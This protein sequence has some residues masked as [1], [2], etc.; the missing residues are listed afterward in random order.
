M[1]ELQLTMFS[2]PLAPVAQ[3]NDNADVYCDCLIESYFVSQVL[4]LQFV[5]WSLFG[6]VS[7]EFWPSNSTSR[8]A[9]SF[10]WLSDELMYH[11]VTHCEECNSIYSVS[12]SQQAAKCWITIAT[13]LNE[14]CWRL[15]AT[16][17]YDECTE[18]G[19][20]EICAK[21]LRNIL[22]LKYFVLFCFLINCWF[23][24]W[25]LLTINQNTTSR[26]RSYSASAP[27]TVY[28]LLFCV[29]IVLLYQ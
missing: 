28:M 19:W 1:V 7:V 23:L 5:F 16:S 10:G 4:L 8:F 3:M 6:S 25:F 12:C 18:D 29:V 21:T 13:G 22:N 14:K 27:G 20:T 11:A 26:E 24:I 2:P 15:V 9:L 17:H